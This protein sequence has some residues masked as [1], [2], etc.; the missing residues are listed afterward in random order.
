MSSMCSHHSKRTC[1]CWRSYPI[2]IYIYNVLH[3]HVADHDVWL[4]LKLVIFLLR[5]SK[6]IL[7]NAMI[8]AHLH[9][10]NR[11][12]KLNSLLLLSLSFSLC[13]S[14]FLILAMAKAQET[15]KS[16][17]VSCMLLV[18][19]FSLLC[20]CIMHAHVCSWFPSG[21]IPNGFYLSQTLTCQHVDTAYGK[22][23]LTDVSWHSMDMTWTWLGQTHV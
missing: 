12:G 21:Q 23:N 5:W 7:F 18:Y 22:G 10:G 11:N 6:D 1:C 2:Y 16:S 8:L 13:F 19:S 3:T 15:V 4:C 20:P 14:P 9:F 17:Y